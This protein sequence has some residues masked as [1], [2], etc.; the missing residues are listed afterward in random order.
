[1]SMD[2]PYGEGMTKNG[3]PQESLTVWQNQVSIKRTL[4]R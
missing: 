3:V 2:P 4:V 1:M